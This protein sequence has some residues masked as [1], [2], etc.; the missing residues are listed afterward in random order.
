MAAG[1]LQLHSIS[2]SWYCAVSLFSG[3]AFFLLVPFPQISAE[4]ACA[5]V[6]AIQIFYI[7]IYMAVGLWQALFHFGLLELC[8]YIVFWLCCLHFWRNFHRFQLQSPW[9]QIGKPSCCGRL[10]VSQVP[11]FHGAILEIANFN[12]NL[13]QMFSLGIQCMFQISWGY[14]GPLGLFIL[15]R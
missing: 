5:M 14:L 8:S 6:F 7:R 3:I 4:F 2:A 11:K 12:A 10:F 9:T 13:L 15:Q 1:Y